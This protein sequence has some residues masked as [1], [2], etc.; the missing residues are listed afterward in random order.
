VLVNYC[1]SSVSLISRKSKLLY[2]LA[3]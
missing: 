3:G 2:L 1:V